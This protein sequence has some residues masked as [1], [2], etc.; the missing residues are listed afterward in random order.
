MR[1]LLVFLLSFFV[2]LAC[3]S[4]DRNNA[5]V[6][7]QAKESGK[8]AGIFKYIKNV[9]VEDWGAAK[10][11][12]LLNPWD[13]TKIW[14]T[15]LLHSKNYQK[16]STWSQFE[17]HVEVPINRVA[18]SSASSIGF[19]EALGELNSVKAISA[20]HHVYNLWVRQQVDNHAIIE[21]V[22]GEF[23]D[24]ERVIAA[25][26]DLL[27]QT[28]MAGVDPFAEKLKNGGVSIFYNADWLEN[29]PLGRAE[30]IKVVALFYD[31]SI[32]ADSI[33]AKIESEYFR[34]QHLAKT[35]AHQPDVIIGTPYKDIWYMPAGNSYKA[36]LLADAG[37]NYHW[38]EKVGNAS[39]PLGF[40]AVVSAQASADF[41]I[42]VPQRNYAEMLALN[43]DFGIFKAFRQQQ[44]YHN[45]LQSHADGANNYWE[46][47]VCRPDELLSDLIRIFH[48][49]LNNAQ[50]HYYSQLAP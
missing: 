25:K 40:E 50:W 6:G 47:G 17:Y 34:L 10:K 27:I 1:I 39:L 9:R 22:S 28:P 44:V 7:N 31:Q 14:H 43:P 30:W 42:E 2:L 35:V 36:I 3:N 13:T 18:L 24:I 45:L 37:A 21:L 12:I 19:I 38:K 4:A 48:P 15:Y 49:K 41:W 11:L 32:Q 20:K 5:L 16:D 8:K 26:T 23:I 46:R 33:F 29:T